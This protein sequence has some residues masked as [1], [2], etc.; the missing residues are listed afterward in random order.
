VYS[1]DLINITGK[2]KNEKPVP[3]LPIH[4]KDPWTINLFVRT[5]QPLENRTII[6][7]FGRAE[8]T[9]SGIG[10]Y[11]C[12]FGRG[13][14]FWASNRDVDAK[15]APL[16]V[17]RWQMLSATYDGQMLR[18]YKNGIAVGEDNIALSDDQATVRI[19]PIDPWDRQ[20]QF[21]G[22]I[23]S[24]TIWATTLSPDAIRVLLGSGPKIES[25][26]TAEASP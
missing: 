25:P 17:G 26:T 4:A 13:L 14:H 5:D 15:D 21:K 9:S 2:T 3:G 12:K 6:A 10:R 1:L 7:G 11:L 20:R 8:D 23:R 18:L 22:E 24:M 16:D 19:A